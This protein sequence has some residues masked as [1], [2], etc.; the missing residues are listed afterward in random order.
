[1]TLAGRQTIFCST[2]H[3]SGVD[4]GITVACFDVLAKY[5][6]LCMCCV[7]APDQELPCDAPESIFGEPVFGGRFVRRCRGARH[8]A[9]YRR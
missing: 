5:V 2:E 4:V 1:M 9:Q 6:V 8:V 7:L 3:V